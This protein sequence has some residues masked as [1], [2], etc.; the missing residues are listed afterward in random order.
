MAKHKDA[1]KKFDLH[2]DIVKHDV[3]F[4]EQE[5][6]P[7]KNRK[8]FVKQRQLKLFFAIVFQLK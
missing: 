3:H 2:F 8:T 6:G 7:V 5:T 1:G 4:R